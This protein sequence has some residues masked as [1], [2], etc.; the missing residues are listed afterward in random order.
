MIFARY[1]SQLRSAIKSC[2]QKRMMLKDIYKWMRA[3]VPEF[4][5]AYK[6][7]PTEASWQVKYGNPNTLH[8]LKS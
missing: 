7:G 8:L 2:P 5:E 6:T 4:S 1:L 3:N